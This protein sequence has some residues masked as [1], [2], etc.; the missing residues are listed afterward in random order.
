MFNSKKFLRTVGHGSGVYLMFDKSGACIYI[1]KAKNLTK[2]LGSYFGSKQ[3]S[4][5]TALMIS[6]IAD[7][8][9]RATSSET[10]AL[11]L[12][13]NLIK[14]KRPRYNITFRDDKSYPYIRI[15]THQEYPRVSFYR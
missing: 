5:K 7:I 11:L 10:E 1:G 15:T 6:Q 14:E 12:E 13:S 4:G 9:I 2:R 8:Q 3:I